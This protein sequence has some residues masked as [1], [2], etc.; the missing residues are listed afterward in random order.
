[1]KKVISILICALFIVSLVGCT[2]SINLLGQS[3]FNTKMNQCEKI[4]EDT[5]N[6]IT[7]EQTKIIK[8]FE[9]KYL[10]MYNTD[11]SDNSQRRNQF[12]SFLTSKMTDALASNNI[13]YL[14]KLI[15]S[16]QFFMVGDYT[17]D[18]Y[19]LYGE[20][21]DRLNI[22]QPTSS[23]QTTNTI[24]IPTEPSIGM[25][26]NEVLNSTWGK[27]ESINKTT[28]VNGTS[29]QWIYSGYRYIYLDN[30]IVTAIQNH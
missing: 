30:G 21:N 25:T 4:I 29:E 6:P 8:D 17:S 27:P 11:G 7:N 26:A 15:D 28:N 2:N 5:S 20:I 10:R 24:I 18:I 22:L 19:K 23:Q 3:E 1:M 9:T 14:N 12:I 16:S 13:D